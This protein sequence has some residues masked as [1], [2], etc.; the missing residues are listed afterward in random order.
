MGRN[1]GESMS[2]Y[3]AYCAAYR[4]YALETE[5]GMLQEFMGCGK[6][7]EPPIAPPAEPIARPKRRKIQSTPARRVRVARKAAK[8]WSVTR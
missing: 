6:Q 4:I 7:L 5:P 1:G 8:N 2:D 3:E